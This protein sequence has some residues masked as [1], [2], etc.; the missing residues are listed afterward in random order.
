MKTAVEFLSRVAPL[1]VLCGVIA[2]GGCSRLDGDPLSEI[3][4]EHEKN[5]YRK[6]LDKLRA[7]LD[8]SPSDPETNFL[9][10]RALM[11]I[12]DSSLA[13]WPLRK[14]AESPEFAVDSGMMLTQAMLMGRTPRDA[15]SAIE[16]VVAMEPDHVEALALRA[17]A[18]LRVDR[19][20]DALAD[21]SRVAELE[22]DNVAILVPRV[23][24]LIY[25]E[26][27]EEAGEA[28]TA[29][30][31]LLETT[32][33]EVSESIRGR[34]CVANGMF[35]FE[36]DQ[37]EEAET[38]YRVC[39]ETYPTNQLVVLETVALIDRLGR[40]EDAT[41]ILRD[42]F[43]Q[44]R[45]SVFG[46]ALA[47][48]MGELGF[49]EE[50]VRL[51][52]EEAEEQNTAASWFALGDFYNQRD[53]FD[54]AVSAFENALKA[55]P[56]PSAMIRF[57]YVDTLIQ[58]GR[59]E[60][61]ERAAKD[62]SP[63]TLRDLLR[64]RIL[65]EQ[66][67]ASGALRLFESGIRLWPNNAGARFLAGQ[68][69][70]RLGD[71]NRA[72]AEYRESVRADSSRTEAGLYLARILEATG[73]DEAAMTAVKRYLLSHPD[74]P[75]GM[76]YLIRL[77]FLNGR[78]EAAANGLQRLGALPGH[79][80]TAMVERMAIIA[81]GP[82]PQAAVDTLV[83][84]EMD[85]TEPENAMVL[86]VLLE[87]LATLDQ[88]DEAK[89]RVAAALEAHPE[90]AAFHDLKARA[91]LAAG[92]PEDEI[93]ESF[94]QAVERD[95]KMVESLISLAELAAAD[96]KIDAAITLYDRASEAALEDLRAAHAAIA[97]LRSAERTEEAES[98]L[99]VL[100]ERNPIDAR[101]ANDLA[102]S[103]AERGGDLDRSLE[104]ARRADY[105]I[106]VPEAPE[107]LGWILL[108]RQEHEPAVEALT[109]AVRRRPDAIR[110][111]YR[112]GRALAANG[113]EESAREAFL[114]VMKTDA[115]E[116][117][118][119]RIEIARLAG[120]E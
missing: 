96:E 85:L 29:A 65:L 89:A 88:H 26:R 59:Y 13:I 28:L 111:R 79:R 27:I 43:E 36:N 98:R 46:S 86:R 61:A 30:K 35:A 62:V 41:K 52:R 63:E 58:A 109:R 5:Q 72:I 50:Q 84:S 54:A 82:G 104:L 44:T 107:T 3:R 51:M 55:E 25:L 12:G 101:S 74:D 47:R 114:E 83:K 106:T 60:D 22:P 32:E 14:A 9:L 100:V 6:S 112:L 90:A 23:I 31:E 24:A 48:R 103:L 76:I 4:E 57:A 49:A 73:N 81:V 116:A 115:P 78:R 94:Q 71:F 91:L 102:E 97:L 8:E 68:A 42:A 105:F 39:L 56:N 77:S 17:Q 40:R 19:H 45:S 1:L 37:P 118:Q 21:V 95:P 20:E 93:R 108:L 34:L 110:A 92:G 53:K 10:G 2:A 70:A 64:G 119:A 7:L 33:Q 99:E 69:A 75:T 117:E 120:A 80:A 66:G 87:Q 11:R 113:D 15:V 18:Y 67:D 38:L 16:P